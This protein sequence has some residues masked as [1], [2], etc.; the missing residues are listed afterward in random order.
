MTSPFGDFSDR[1]MTRGEWQS[2]GYYIP[3][4]ITPAADLVDGDAK[5]PLFHTSQV[6]NPQTAKIVI[7]PVPDP[8]DALGGPSI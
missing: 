5:F 6:V 7:R 4:N 3:Y 2:I 1:Y 8:D